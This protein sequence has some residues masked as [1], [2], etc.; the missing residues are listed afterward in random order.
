[1]PN[2]W[3]R[4]RQRD[5]HCLGLDRN[6]TNSIYTTLQQTWNLRDEW[7][8]KNKTVVH[9]LRSP[10]FGEEM[11]DVPVSDVSEPETSDDE[12]M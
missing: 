1:M 6:P 8:E 9:D 12:I 5:R 4:A 2:T 3:N 11:N 7:L 10:Y